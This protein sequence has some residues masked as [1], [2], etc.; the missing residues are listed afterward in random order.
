MLVAA[1]NTK[2]HLHGSGG[3]GRGFGFGSG[4]FVDVLTPKTW[5]KFG[6]KYI[7][8]DSFIFDKSLQLPYNIVFNCH[9]N[10]Y[11]TG[12]GPHV[13]HHEEVYSHSCWR[14]GKLDTWEPKGLWSGLDPVHV[15][16]HEQPPKAGLYLK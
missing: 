3:V 7:F 11:H 2:S 6:G 8:I 10:T 13:G 14:I 15:R 16:I 1:S 12:P 4:L 9:K 5:Y